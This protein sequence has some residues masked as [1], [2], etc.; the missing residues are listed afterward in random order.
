MSY[1]GLLGSE[2]TRFPGQETTDIQFTDW[3]NVQAPPAGAIRQR[4]IAFCQGF[5]FA[6]IESRVLVQNPAPG[7]PPALVWLPTANYVPNVVVTNRGPSPP[8]QINIPW[9][10]HNVATPMPSREFDLSCNVAMGRGT[11]YARLTGPG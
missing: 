11:A 5:T 9:V 2:G 1:K 3:R 6:T 8:N 7:A 10:S 4:A